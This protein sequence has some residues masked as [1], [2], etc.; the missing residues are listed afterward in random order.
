MENTGISE[1]KIGKQNI[2]NAGEYYIA[3]RLSAENFIT[4]ITLGRAEKYDIL[5]VNSL[6]KTIKLSVKTRFKEVD[7]FPLSKKDEKGGS[8]GFYYAFIRLNEFIREPDFWIIPSK[9]VNEL[10]SAEAEEYYFHQVK[11]NGEKHNDTGLRVLY[12][13]RNNPTKKA[14]PDDWEQE[15]KTYEKN[16]NQ[17]K[18]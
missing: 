17:L 6:G 3:A 14:F 18:K 5:A 2:G 9:R 16:I 10:I 4:T 8:E 13:K 1:N 12:L 15:L 11:R 7:R